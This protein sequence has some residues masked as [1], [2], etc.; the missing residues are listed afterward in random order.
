M[1]IFQKAAAGLNLTPGERALL[2]LLQGFALAG[3][4]AVVMAAPALVSWRAGQPALAAGAASLAAGAFVHAFL[5][6]WAKYASAKGDLPLTSA[7][8][9]VSTAIPLPAAQAPAPTSA[10]I[11]AA[12]MIAQPP[13][14]I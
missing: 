1:N 14:A 11:A 2:K 12:G 13:A 5:A 3:V 7:I 8:M 10:Q 9:S 4:L 6:A